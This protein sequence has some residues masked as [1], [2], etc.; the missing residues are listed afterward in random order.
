MKDHDTAPLAGASPDEVAC[1]KLERVE[2][3]LRTSE[4]RYRTLFENSHDALMTLAPP[5][6][7]FTSC[8]AA[9]RTVFA[10]PEGCDFTTL[11]PWD[12]SPEVQADGRPSGEKAAEVIGIAMEHGSNFFEWTHCR[13]QGEAFPATVLLN[14]MELAGHPFLQA[15]VRDITAQ[16]QV[17]LR[18]QA[19]L[20]E[21]EI[22]FKEV[23]HRVKNNLAIV[24]ALFSLQAREE[25]DPRVVGKLLD[26]ANRVK[27]MSLVHEMLY[28][29][30]DLT[31][32]NLSGYLRNL[33]AHLAASL[34]ARG[35]PLLLREPEQQLLLSLDDAVPCGL[36]L[37]ELITN[38]I[39]HSAST[40]RQG[41]I[42][43]STVVHEGEV[44]VRILDLSR[45][46]LPEAP[47]QKRQGLGLRIV[48]NL[49][50]QLGGTL[51]TEHPTETSTLTVV[52]FRPKSKY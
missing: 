52:R 16:K 8:N 47:P 45:P 28:S 18:L 4:E 35:T 14:R 36:I 39:K 17:E 32:V 15:T 19:S 23:H 49:V 10:I 26:G 2:A 9:T 12:L 40:E 24:S 25:D 33:V 6:W 44:M 43:V 20:A 38:S 37:N 34:T 50:S 22:L 7:L 13:Y 3:D 11:G 31:R 27:A 21:K 1:D 29:S 5:A 46:R 51:T 48:E 30:G 42:E 41:V